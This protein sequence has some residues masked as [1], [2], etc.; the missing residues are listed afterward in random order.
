MRQRPAVFVAQ[1]AVFP[2]RERLEGQEWELAGQLCPRWDAVRNASSNASSA[3]WI[4]KV[5]ESL[6]LQ[7]FGFKLQQERNIPRR[8]GLLAFRY[9]AGSGRVAKS[10]A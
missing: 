4:E 5:L 1:N 3:R 9:G 10:D 8:L 7:P 6:L 2:S